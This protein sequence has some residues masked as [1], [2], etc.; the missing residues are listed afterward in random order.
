[1]RRLRCLLFLVAQASRLCRRRLK[2]GYQILPGKYFVQFNTLGLTCNWDYLGS[3]AVG[4]G[5]GRF[6]VGRALQEAPDRGWGFGGGG[7]GPRP[8]PPPP[9]NYPPTTITLVPTQLTMK[10]SGKATASLVRARKP[11]QCP[12]MIS[13]GFSSFRPWMV[14]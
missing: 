6:L 1:M 5:P 9:S 8:L 2:P 13:S 3:R 11:V 12:A 4:L 7:K 14:C 10:V